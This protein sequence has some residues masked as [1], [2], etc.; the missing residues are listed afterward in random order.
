M[1]C[2]NCRNWIPNNAAFCQTCGQRIEISQPLSSPVKS[3]TGLIAA[4]LVLGVVAIVAVA[5]LF[6]VMQQRQVT[7]TPSSTYSPIQSSANPPEPQRPPTSK[8]VMRFIWFGAS[9]SAPIQ[10]GDVRVQAGSQTFQKKTSGK[11]WLVLDGVPCNQNAKIMFGRG[12]LISRNVGELPFPV[13]VYNNL[14][15]TRYVPC[16]DK[17]VG[18]GAFSWEDGDFI[19]DDMDNIDACYT[20]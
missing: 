20:C 8:I 9:F 1:N 7:S 2:P 19:G 17:P 18:L 3:N 15:V 6:L 5:G 4:L 16:S 12:G 14:Q 11:G 10:K 13:D